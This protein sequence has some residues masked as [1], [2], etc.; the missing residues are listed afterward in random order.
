M[1]FFRHQWFAILVCGLMLLYAMQR[2]LLS[3]QNIN[4]LPS[5]ILLG[6]FLIPVV[7]VAYLYEKL[8]TWEISFA[9]VA[10]CFLWGGVVG[11]LVAGTLEYATLRSLGILSMFGVGLIEETAKL[12]FPVGFHL[13]GRYRSESTGIILGTACAMGFAALETMGYSFV[14]ILRSNGNITTLDSVLFARGLFS[15]AGHAAWTGFVC[16]VLWRERERAGRAIVTR[17]VIWAFITAVV[18]HALWDIFQS[19]RGAT[20]ISFLSIEILSLAVAL[21]SLNLLNLRVEECIR[22]P[23]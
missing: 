12:I 21:I 22:N 4:F 10:I 23:N 20:F 11:T 19:L 14:A 16:A 13:E 2:V 15:P 3:T 7:Y 1:K 18:L 17:K 5:L 6:S 8:P 9:P